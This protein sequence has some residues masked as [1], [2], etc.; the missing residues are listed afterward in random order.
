MSRRVGQVEAA[1]DVLVKLRAEVG[2]HLHEEEDASSKDK[3]TAMWSRLQEVALHTEQ[4]IWALNSNK[5]HLRYIAR[6]YLVPDIYKRTEHEVV[7]L[8]Q[9]YQNVIAECEHVIEV[10][11]LIRMGLSAQM[12]AIYSHV[13]VANGTAAHTH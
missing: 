10:C 12:R 5:E 9:Q 1:K 7:P 11:K 4:L 2:K 6:I 8:R 13:Q 3:L